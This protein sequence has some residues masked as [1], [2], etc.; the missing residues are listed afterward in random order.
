MGGRGA[1]HL[2]GRTRQADRS[3]TF[4]GIVASGDVIVHAR[5]NLD[6]GQRWQEIRDVPDQARR[7]ISMADRSRTS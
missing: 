3:E 6:R 4:N 7:S 2:F 1:I 5:A